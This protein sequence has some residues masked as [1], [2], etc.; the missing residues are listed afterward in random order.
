VPKDA[1]TTSGIPSPSV[2]AVELG[3]TTV[4]RSVGVTATAELPKALVPNSPNVPATEP[5]LTLRVADV[6]LGLTDAAVTARAELWKEKPAPV[7]LAPVTT[8]LVAVL[9]RADFL[10]SKVMIGS[11]P[12]TTFPMLVVLPRTGVTAEDVPPSDIPLT[13]V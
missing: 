5:A 1:S 10:L 9:K 2:S 3:L 4:N 8:T 6:P 11:G 12:I 13:T 7:R